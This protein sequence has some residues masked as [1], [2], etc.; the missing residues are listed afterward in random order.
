[1]LGKIH[2]VSPRILAFGT[3]RN[4]TVEVGWNAKDWPQ[5][6]AATTRI[7]EST[8]FEVLMIID[9]WVE[10]IECVSSVN[11]SIDSMLFSLKKAMLGSAGFV[12]T[13]VGNWAFLRCQSARERALMMSHGFGGKIIGHWTRSTFLHMIITY[14]AISGNWEQRR[15]VVQTNSFERLQQQ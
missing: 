14:D 13:V 8:R 5:K 6:T 7:Q 12:L 9:L 15:P 4:P 1:M 2:R 3:Y 11:N 10:T